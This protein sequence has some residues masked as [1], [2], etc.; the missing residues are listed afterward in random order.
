MTVLVLVLETVQALETTTVLVLAIMTVQ[1]LET[2]LVRA[3]ATTE[4][5]T[6]TALVISAMT[7]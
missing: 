1:A 6:T 4:P 2:V 5:V 3:R 7:T